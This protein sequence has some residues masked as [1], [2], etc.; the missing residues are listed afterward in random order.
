M[1]S[2]FLKYM[3]KFINRYALE[4]YTVLAMAFMVVT[5]FMNKLSSIQLFV[6]AFNFIFILH[7]WEENVYPGGFINLITQLIEREVDEDTKRAS[8]IPTGVLLI[9]LTLLPFI[10]DNIPLFS[11]S[12]AVFGI[13]ECFIHIMGIKIFG[14]KKKYTPGMVTALCEGAL[15]I[16]LIVF[17]AVNH[18]GAWY[19]YVGG[20]FL[21][22]ALFMCM[23]K[24]LTL[25]VGMR[26][27]DLPKLMKKQ[28]QRMRERR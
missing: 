9:T 21:F 13:F 7:E 10:F 1:T 18:L 3:G 12:I 20:F 11:V 24:T 28:L 22:I 26:Y 17:L 25:M 5:S 6:V 4:I 19:H 8:R 16:C 14:L 2:S 23:Q 15:G 27:R